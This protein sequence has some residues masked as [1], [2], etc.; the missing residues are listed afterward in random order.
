MRARAI[1]GAI[2]CLFLLSRAGSAWAH[3]APLE[4][5]PA[6]SAVLDAPPTEVHIGFSERVEPGASSIQV[7]APDGTAAEVG[8]P[9]VSSDDRRRF[10]VK[11]SSDDEGTHT[12]SWQVVSADDGHFT[13]GAY[14]FSVRKATAVAADDQG[15]LISH[16]SPGSEAASIWLELLGFALLIGITVLGSGAGGD[17]RPRF[18]PAAIAGVAL[19]IVGAALGL[20]VKSYELSLA[21]GV[22]LS[23][24]F[25][26]Y[27]GTGAGTYAAVRAAASLFWLA[28]YSAWRR[29]GSGARPFM[30]L[31]ILASAYAR[32]R[33]SHAAASHLWPVF[34]IAVNAAHVMAKSLWIGGTAVMAIVVLPAVRKGRRGLSAAAALWSKVAAISVG[35]VGVTGAYIV[36]LHLKDP[37]YLLSTDWGGR[38]LLLTAVG[39]LL[40]GIR[41]WQSAFLTPSPS[42]MWL[43]TGFGAVLLLVTAFMIITTPPLGIRPAFQK[44]VVNEGVLLTLMERADDR[45]SLLLTARDA[46]TGTA[47]DTTD[48]VVSLTNEERAVGPIVAAAE[49]RFPGGYAIPEDQFLPSGLWKIDVVARHRGGYDATA[50]FMLDAPIEIENGRL[51]A[52]ERRGGPID[53]YSLAAALVA[54]TLAI[55]LYF[56]RLPPRV[57]SEGVRTRCAVILIATITPLLLAASRELLFKGAFQRACEGRGHYWNLSVPVREGRVASQVAAY[58]CSFGSGGGAFHITDEREYA[59]FTRSTMSFALL[60][61]FP[62]Q[63]M[64]GEPVTMTITMLDEDGSPLADMTMEHERLL[65]VIVVG[66]DMRTFDH[67]HVEDRGPITDDMRRTGTYQVE[68]TF[69][70]AGTYMIGIDYA[71]RGEPRGQQFLVDVRGPTPMIQEGEI[72]HRMS[73]VDGYDVALTTSPRT[74][75]ANEQAKILFTIRKDGKEIADLQPYLGAAMHIVAANRD[76]VN[77]MRQV[78]RPSGSVSSILSRLFGALPAQAHIVPVDWPPDKVPFMHAHG[79]PA[80]SLLNVLMTGGNQHA[81]HAMLPRAFGPKV[82]SSVVFSS[83]GDYVIFAEFKH[84]GVTHVSRF[85]V[86]VN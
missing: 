56:G 6:A 27:L 36:W 61:T 18:D 52:E 26:R 42:L 40:V 29:G 54:A 67:I 68:Y 35:L 2:V 11:V 64:A 41:I 51:E 14:T 28:A 16:S 4:Y 48:V 83:P 84:D 9:Y 50:S 32:A 81:A 57:L 20:A 47:V 3:A 53:A 30:W 44:S 13:K 21:Q 12:V 37:A 80:R 19:A 65:H 77:L 33:I 72:E 1:I 45:T 58:G 78:P 63:P 75:R 39:G 60:D 43:E 79:I 86:V 62:V 10:A 31:F 69:P 38:F 46:E 55:L 76:F 24:A 7:F 73:T 5:W 8:T 25:G 71:V 74:L 23:A 85:P 59:F 82:E 17:T 22:A 49:E 15:F 66:S 70:L 34:S